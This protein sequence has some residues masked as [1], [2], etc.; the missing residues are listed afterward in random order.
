MINHFVHG[1]LHGDKPVWLDVKKTRQ[2]LK[3][4]RLVHRACEI[5]QSFED[6]KPEKII[7]T[8]DMRSKKVLR[9][10]VPVGAS[11]YGKWVWEA[12]GLENYTLEQRKHTEEWA[13]SE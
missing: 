2:Q 1:P 12:A 7:L 11:L 13:T 10:G 3:P 5:M 9:D 6:K 8:K 4:L